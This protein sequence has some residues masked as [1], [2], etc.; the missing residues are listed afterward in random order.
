VTG[1]RHMPAPPEATWVG[2]WTFL[3]PSCGHQYWIR[4]FGG[5]SWTIETSSPD[6]IEVELAGSQF[7]DGSIEMW[8][9]LEGEIHDLE[10][11]EA[12]M[13]ASTLS[14]TVDELERTRGG[15]P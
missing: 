1:L 10:A 9:H 7:A 3:Q 11:D 13:L 2:E 6:P 4:S 8:I 12:L 15:R 5:R 14:H